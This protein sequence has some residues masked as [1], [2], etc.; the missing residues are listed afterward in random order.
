MLVRPSHKVCRKSDTFIFVEKQESTTTSTIIIIV[1]LVSKHNASTQTSE[2]TRR[3]W[4]AD[5]EPACRRRA[6]QKSRIGME[7]KW[8]RLPERNGRNTKFLSDDYFVG[9]A[10]LN[11]F[12]GKACFI[13]KE[14]V[15]EREMAPR[16][17][18]HGEARIVLRLRILHVE[19]WPTSIWQRE[20]KWVACE[21]NPFYSAESG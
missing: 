2:T 20:T 7:L 12:V 5:F 10:L 6:A 3:K 8:V 13:T 21:D 15:K 18:K 9:E 19:G 11:Y 1:K 14:K 17:A 4:M 16:L